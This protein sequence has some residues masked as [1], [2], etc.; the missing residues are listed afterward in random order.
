[1][2]KPFTICLSGGVSEPSFTALQ[3]LARWAGAATPPHLAWE[4][5]WWAV[6]ILRRLSIA[7]ARVIGWIVTRAPGDR[8][9]RY[10]VESQMTDKGTRIVLR[11][12]TGGQGAGAR[13]EEG[14]QG[15]RSSPGDAGGGIEAGAMRR[16]A[17]DADDAV[18]DAAVMDDAYDEL[19]SAVVGSL[20]L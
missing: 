17:G 15:R 7:M 5:N 4:P 19:C 2:L 3:T 6:R 20:L 13:A 10:L 14:Q 12:P 11:R 8:Y 18:M 9:E 16:G 1:M